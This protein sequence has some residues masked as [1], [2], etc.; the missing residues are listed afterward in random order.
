M[1]LLGSREKQINE[2]SSFMCKQESSNHQLVFLIFIVK[3][4]L[5][6]SGNDRLPSAD[7]LSQDHSV[8]TPPAFHSHSKM[9]VYIVRA[10]IYLFY[11]R[12]SSVNFL[13]QH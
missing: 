7:M 13:D 1:Q 11:K 12:T 8:F 9:S 4:T 3:G 2:A 10:F 5:I 6:L